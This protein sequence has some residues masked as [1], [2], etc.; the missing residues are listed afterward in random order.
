M[1]RGI[2]I[3]NLK[4]VGILTLDSR[5]YNYGGVLQEYALLTAIKELG[6]SC[7][8]IDYDLYSECGMFSYKR[9]IRYLT[10]NRVIQKLKERRKQR[11]QAS[12]SK[13]PEVKQEIQER[14]REFDE[15][16]E[17]FMIFSDRCDRQG[18]YAVQKK[19]DTVVCGSD[20]IWNPRQ[21]V[22][23]FFLDFVED[24]RNKIIYA[25]SISMDTLNDIEERV[26]AKYLKNL[27]K[28]SVREERAKELLQDVVK[29][30]EISVVLDPVL[31]L[32]AEH[33][34]K[35]AGEKPLISEKY[36]FCYL[37]GIDDNKRNAAAKFAKEH[38]VKIIS[39]PYLLGVYNEL[40]SGF[41]TYGLHIGPLEFLNLILHADY[42]LSDSF[43]A[44][45]FSI[46][47]QKKFRV[48][49]RVN[50]NQSGDS[51]LDTLL[52]Y[53]GHEEFL[54]EPKKLGEAGIEADVL[55]DV[56]ELNRQKKLSIKWLEKNIEN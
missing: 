28:I 12:Y 29:D 10:F 47:F 22:P 18:L 54:V 33:W 1:S 46:L 16:R 43:H 38:G 36:V 7:E 56:S 26:F 3:F 9:N 2:S 5:S 21:C 42:V 24:D 20:Q 48:F 49:S 30:K 19:Y 23:S 40:D 39:I 44:S 34:K 11:F 45:V 35:L 37:L 32:D 41:S 50:G 25:A 27:N 13:L 51:R 8:I 55:Y 6:Y 15:F 52:G 31:L 4:K 17:H 14:Y 53:I